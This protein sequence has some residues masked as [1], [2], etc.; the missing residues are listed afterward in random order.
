METT[1]IGPSMVVCVIVAWCSGGLDGGIRRCSDGCAGYLK[2]VVTAGECDIGDEKEWTGAVYGH[3]CMSISVFGEQGSASEARDATVP[4]DIQALSYDGY[5]TLRSQT[6]SSLELYEFDQLP[7]NER[8]DPHDH[9][10]D[11]DDNMV[12]DEPEVDVSNLTCKQRKLM[13]S[14]KNARGSGRV[15]ADANKK[16]DL[17]QLK[18]T[19]ISSEAVKQRVIICLR[20]VVER[21]SSE[22]VRLELF[23]SDKPSLLAEVTRTF[24]ENLMNVTEDEISTFTQKTEDAIRTCVAWRFSKQTS[25]YDRMI[26]QWI[27]DK[28]Y[29]DYMYKDVSVKLYLI[30]KVKKRVLLDEKRNA[31]VDFDYQTATTTPPRS[32]PISS[33]SPT[34]RRISTPHH[35]AV[36]VAGRRRQKPKKKRNITM[37]MIS[38]FTTVNKM[39]HNSRTTRDLWLSLEKAYA[40]HSTSREYTLKTQ[41]LRI[42]MHGDE[43]PDAYLNC[44]QEYVD[45]LVAISEPIKEQDLVMLVVL[46]LHE[47]YNGLKTT[48]T[49]RQRPT[50]FSE[51]H[52]LLSDHD[53]MLGKTR[54]PASS[55]TSSFAA[56]YTVGSPSMLEARHA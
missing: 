4:E 7:D 47:E 1:T 13:G 51:L 40:P 3:T 32:D 20:A 23:K 30:S 28:P 22:G 55:I 46:G 33:L 56:N 49:A 29:L 15:K 10:N 54:A 52:A 43:T 45:A 25:L 53:Y 31:D 8:S 39:T 9:P 37:A 27:D 48:I 41:I 24:R 38:A 44:A 2:V 50:A 19:P 6:N 14:R 26:G 34:I 36:A 18:G 12:E 11:D 35:L 42:E 21:K 16:S 17:L 5:N